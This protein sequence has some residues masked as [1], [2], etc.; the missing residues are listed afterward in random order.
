LMIWSI[1]AGCESDR[2]ENPT[3]SAGAGVS[4]TEI[5]IGSSC[6][7]SGHASFLG[8]KIVHGVQSYLNYV[9][10]QGGINGR[11]IRLITYD[12]A[13]DPAQCI[14]NTQRL[15]N[16]DRVFALTSYVGTPTAVKVIPMV[17]EAKVP[18]VGIFSGARALR[19]P[20]QRYIINIRAS[21]FEETGRLIDNFVQHFGITHVAIF[22]QYDDFGFDGLSGTEIALRKHGLEPVAKASYVRGSMDVENAAE[23]IGSSDAEAVVMIGTYGP[24]AKFVRLVK[25]RKSTMIFHAVSFVGAEELVKILGPEAE[26]IIITQ[27]VPPPWETV[28]LPA[29]DKYTNL[30]SRYFPEEQPSF[31]GFE[32]YINAVVLVEGIKRA[33]R[34]LTREGLIGSIEGIHQF[35]LE[36]A[37]TLTY[38]PADH[39]GLRHVYF[40][41]IKDGKPALITKWEQIKKDSTVP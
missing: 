29:A 27:V 7:L 12:D 11:K 25:Q 17:Q 21:Y 16:E 22:Y 30:L 36:I 13:Y 33:G 23:L 37:N 10:D 18:L 4:D 20:F 6:P 39:Q 3:G 28:L 26:G 19:E 2:P 24:C 31:V 40:T 14:T 32:G 35:S 41:R 9:N 8:T 38:S 5:L 34:D 1:M 15:I